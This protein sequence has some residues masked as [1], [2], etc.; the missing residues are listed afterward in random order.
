MRSKLLLVLFLVGLVV[1]ARLSLFTVDRTEYVY[2][3]QFGRHVRTYDG[4]DEDE[5]GLHFKLPWP[6]QS[7]Q[8]IDRRLQ[9]FDLPGA[10]LMTLD[11]ER[12]TIDK[13]LTVDAYVCWRVADAEAVDRFTRSVGTPEGA[14]QIL[15]QHIN[16][17]LGTVVSRKQ[18]DDLISIQPHKDHP[19][20]RRVDVERERLR[21][22][23]L[24]GSGVE[25]GLMATAKEKYGVEVVDVRLRRTSHPPAVRE[26]IFDRIRSEREKKSTDY[27][28]QGQQKAADI[29]SESERRVSEM[30]AQAE[31]EA[32]RLRGLAD[33][34]A[35]AIRNEA[36]S[37]DPQF[38]TF[39][40][41]LEDYQK[42]LGDSKT[43]LLLS[44][45]RELFDVLFNPPNPAGMKP[46][47][48]AA[49]AD[50]K[51]GSQ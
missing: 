49:G 12:N 31:A 6:I 46:G 2:L 1:L 32:V 48:A 45:H 16:S 28:S 36:Q 43:M 35:D 41:K 33:A 10:E 29:K 26:A 21:D 19:D 3:T 18:F 7:V 23:L 40:K 14:R 51:G 27:R 9:Y 24:N 22:R 17:E 25:K 5:A 38:Y 30:K 15:G 50:K 44:T 4:A 8:R 20:R 34:E 42:I 47:T 11:P 13:T 39:L 37:K